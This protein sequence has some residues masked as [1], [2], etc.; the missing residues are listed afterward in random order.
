VLLGAAVALALGAGLAGTA[1]VPRPAPA[2]PAARRIGDDVL[3]LLA[4]PAAERPRVDVVA[5]TT[6][7]ASLA[8]YLREVPLR[9]VAGPTAGE[10]GERIVLVRTARPRDWQP[11]P[12]TA[13]RYA[14]RDDGETVAVVELH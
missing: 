7:D 3:A 10:D 5:E 13:P 4:R 1:D 14:L 9:W 11:P 6:I 2:L 8:W 12:S